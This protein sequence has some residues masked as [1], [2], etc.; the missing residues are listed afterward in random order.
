[1]AIDPG[2]E[3]RNV[4]EAHEHKKTAEVVLGGS[5]A[6]ALVGAGAAILAIIGLANVFPGYMASIATIAVGAAL[7]FQGGALVARYADLAHEAGAAEIGGGVSAEVL[8]GLAGMALGILAL[9]G[10]LPAVLTPIAII[11]FGGALLLDSAATVRL[12]ALS[13]SHM[14][15]RARELTRGA[16]EL[17][18]GTETLIGIGA[19]TLGILALVGMA[20]RTL[21]LCALLAVGATVLFTGSAVSGRMLSIF[22]REPA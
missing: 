6:E 18:S 12:N 7:F 16:I 19:V 21:V 2:S 13:S 22:R 15:T 1:M 4:Y 8:G 9:L 20:P 3:G 14:S 5:A 11:V 10:V 17:A